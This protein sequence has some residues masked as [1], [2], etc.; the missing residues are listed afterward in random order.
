[1]NEFFCVVSLGRSV[2]FPQHCMFDL[3]MQLDGFGTIQLSST[4]WPRKYAFLLP[5]TIEIVV[6][7]N[8]CEKKR[9]QW[10]MQIRAQCTDCWPLWPFSHTHT[11]LSHTQLCHT[12]LCH[13]LS[14]THIF[15]THTHTS[16]SHTQAFP[17]AL[18]RSQSLTHNFVTYNF[19]H[20]IFWNA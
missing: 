14:L 7:I 3:R 8:A 4:F 6:K 16:L 5:E 10:N 1:M 19:S 11:T 17:T 12:Q 2:L 20:T 9:A 18:S 15:V 13:T